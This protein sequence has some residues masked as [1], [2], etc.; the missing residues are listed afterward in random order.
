MSD[1]GVNGDEHLGRCH[2]SAFGVGLTHGTGDCFGKKHT[3]PTIVMATTSGV[4]ERTLLVSCMDA[5]RSGQY[6]E[7]VQKYEGL[8]SLFE[9]EMVDRITDMGMFAKLI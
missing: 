9:T 1:V 6:Q 2:T 7:A 5:A 3:L 8:S 4:Q